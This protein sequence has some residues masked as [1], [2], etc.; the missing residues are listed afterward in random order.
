MDGEMKIQLNSNKKKVIQ[1][2][3][4]L[5]QFYAMNRIPNEMENH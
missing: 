5:S 1:I 2:S 3:I 4:S